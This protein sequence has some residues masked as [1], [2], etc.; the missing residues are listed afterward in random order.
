MV[1]WMDAVFRIVVE[2]VIERLGVGVNNPLK[3]IVELPRAD[4][5][6]VGLA[7]VVA[8]FLEVALPVAERVA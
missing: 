1:R 2:I 5:M 4:T 6:L 8:V 3:L 7:V